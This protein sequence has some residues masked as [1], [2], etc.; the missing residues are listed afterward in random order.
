MIF[1]VN[2]SSDDHDNSNVMMMSSMSGDLVMMSLIRMALM[3]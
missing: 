3:I 2:E 1:G